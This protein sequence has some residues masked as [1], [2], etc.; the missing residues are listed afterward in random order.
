LPIIDTV[1]VM[2]E[3]LMKRGNPFAPDRTHVHHRFLDLG[4]H[5]RFTVLIIQGL[6][7]FWAMIALIFYKQPAHWLFFSYI[8][9]S[10]LFYAVL[11]LLLKRK[12]SLPLLKRDS[13]RSLRE[14]YLFMML[15]KWNHRVDPILAFLLLVF[16]AWTALSPLDVGDQVFRISIVLLLVSSV[17]FFLARDLRNPFLMALL[18]MSGMVIAFQSEQLGLT[19]GGDVFSQSA[20]RNLLFVLG[21]ALVIF[22]VTF[23]NGERVLAHPSMDFLLFAMS[24]S[25]AILSPELQLTYRLQEVILKGIV[26]FVTFKILAVHSRPMLRY[27]FWGIHGL[28]LTF[29]LRGL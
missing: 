15:A 10:I 6:T 25:L 7:L 11:R 12:D 3:R 20:F 5:H 23:R 4:F 9:L 13:D 24:L 19:S 16:F 26:L 8:I 14:S 22:K 27:V 21:G 28:L 17:S 1:R 2:S 29:V 18:F